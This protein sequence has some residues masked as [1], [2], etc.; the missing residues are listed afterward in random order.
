MSLAPAIEE[1]L[2]LLRAA[3]PASIEID[4]QIDADLPPVS[5]DATQMHQVV[6]NLA[7]NASAAMAG[8]PGTLRVR[9][10][11]AELDAFAAADAGVK[12]GRFV[13]LTIED[14]GCGMPPEV[15]ERI[16]DPFFTTK[17]PGEGT[18]LGLSVVHGIVVAHEGTIRV[19]SRVGLGTSF[20][21]WFPAQDVLRPEHQRV[22]QRTVTGQGEHVLCVDDE[23]SLVELLREQLTALGYRVTAHASAL[24]ALADFL[25]HPLDFD[26]M[27]TDLTMPG[28]SGAD[29][30]DRVR[31]VRPDL[32]IVMATGYGHVMSEERARELGIRPLL[33]KPFT[34]AVLGEA[35]Q[36][37]LQS[38]RA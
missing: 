37:A 15:L 8:G 30:A 31:K 32:P 1:A 34:M 17:G 28:M 11:D 3:I 13:C 29:L 2:K 4:A 21:I 23:P 38:V 16:F 36:D 20:R 19:D 24:E 35:I 22:R 27:L 7:A 18:G 14:T 5:A 9:V 26:V 12:A 25:N 6:M 33:Q 10:R